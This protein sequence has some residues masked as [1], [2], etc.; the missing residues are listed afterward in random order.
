MLVSKVLAYPTRL[1]YGFASRA[2]VDNQWTTYGRFVPF[3]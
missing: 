3:L 1:G 2:M